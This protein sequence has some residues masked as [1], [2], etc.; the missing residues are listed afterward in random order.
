MGAAAPVLFIPPFLKGGQGDL[1]R[2]RLRAE[3]APH[4]GGRGEAL[5][6]CYKLWSGKRN[7]FGVR[8]RSYWGFWLFLGVGCEADLT[9]GE[10]CDT[11]I[12]RVNW[13]ARALF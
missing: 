2:E 11:M 7:F 10:L 4:F 13:V 9:N 1:I 6:F 3:R 8:V 12:L 5:F